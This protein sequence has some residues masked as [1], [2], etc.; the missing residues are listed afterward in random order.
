MRGRVPG[1]AAALSGPSWSP[2][3]VTSF[4]YLSL[5]EVLAGYETTAF[6]Y[7]QTGTGKTYTMEGHLNSV[8]GRGLVPRT[9]AA[10]LE[11]LASWRVLRPF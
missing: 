9:A 7:G 2:Q 5:S 3:R 4:Q 8:E 6:A 1:H 10:V 11:A